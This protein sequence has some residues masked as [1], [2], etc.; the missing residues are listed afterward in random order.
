[1]L[2]RAQ[3]RTLGTSYLIGPYAYSQFPLEIHGSPSQITSVLVSLSASQ[4]IAYFVI[5]MNLCG[6]K[7]E[8]RDLVVYLRY[9]LKEKKMK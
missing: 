3:L 6:I 8:T 1:M 9:Q 2:F 7:S 5:L 4:S